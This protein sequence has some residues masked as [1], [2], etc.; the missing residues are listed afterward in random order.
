MDLVSP[1]P[2]QDR[3]NKDQLRYW[4]EARSGAAEDQLDHGAGNHQRQN[5]CQDAKAD[6]RYYTVLSRVGA[7]K[8]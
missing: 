2:K 6:T 8:A 3:G 4:D 7:G 1:K 5:E